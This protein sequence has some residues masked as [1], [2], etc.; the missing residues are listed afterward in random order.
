[1]A[2]TSLAPLRLALS[3]MTAFGFVALLLA[4]V[5]IYGVL[6]YA[7]TQKTREIGVRMAL[8]QAPSEVRGVVMRQGARLVGAAVVLGVIASAG[9]SGA[10]ANLLYEVEPIDPV[11]Y[12]ATSAVLVTVALLACWIPARR[13]TRVDPA[14]ALR[15]Q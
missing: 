14:V 2:S 3:L 11:T 9:L 1:M 6:T 13:A 4:T 5:G 10:A 8:G 12:M 15:E 7:V